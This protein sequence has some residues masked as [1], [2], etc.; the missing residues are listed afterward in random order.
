MWRYLNLEPLQKSKYFVVVNGACI[1]VTETSYRR[2]D[3]IHLKQTFRFVECFEASP[4]ISIRY[5]V[6]ILFKEI[7]GTD[8]WVT[9]KDLW[10]WCER[11]LNITNIDAL[12]RRFGY[13]FFTSFHVDLNPFFM[14]NYVPKSI[15]GFN[16]LKN[17]VLATDNRYHLYF[18][19]SLSAHVHH[20]TSY[21]R[22][23]LEP[24]DDGISPYFVLKLPHVRVA[25]MSFLGCTQED[26][27]VCR[28]GVDAFDCCRFHTLRIR[29]EA[30]C[31]VR[32]VPMDG[33]ESP[34]L[35]TVYHYG[36]EPLKVEPTS[37]QVRCEQ[38]TPQAV[39]LV[40]SKPP[41][42]IVRHQLSGQM[43]TICCETDHFISTGD[44]LCSFH[45]QKGV[46]RIMDEVPILDDGIRPDLVVNPFC[47]FRMTGGQFIEGLMLGEG[48][49]ATRVRNSRGE[50]VLNGSVFYSKMFYFLLT[51]LAVEHIYFP[52]ECTV[53]LVTDQAMKGR[54]RCG[55]MRLGNMELY[56]GLE[57]NGLGSCF[58]EI[59]FEHSDF[60]KTNRIVPKSMELVQQDACFY[61]CKIWYDSKPPVTL[62]VSR[63]V[64]DRVFHS[65]VL[66]ER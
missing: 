8:L 21:H 66:W 2:L 33:Y 54:S 44:K 41:F 36:D 11:M 50:D 26:S 55:G 42:R 48:R 23:V 65:G 64:L 1:P 20:V 17:A 3:L 18:M 47:F 13:D 43:L 52:R 38:L 29:I 7:P 58:Q 46:L 45:G 9:P 14:H 22:T 49:D 24:M 27:I 19:D 28:R 16:A 5:K 35:G 37:I 34:V 31:M 15:L 51:Y 62:K 4:F 57:G 10:Y 25:Y 61:K 59:F 6:G 12:A 60:A 53:D 40:F 63:D 30:G 39:R 32:F 56:N